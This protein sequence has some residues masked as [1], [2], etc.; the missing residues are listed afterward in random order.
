MANMHPWPRVG[1]A[2]DFVQHVSVS[3][4]EVWDAFVNEDQLRKWLRVTSA[5]I[6]LVAGERYH[7]TTEVKGRGIDRV[8]VIEGKVAAVI[9]NRLLALEWKLLYAGE[10]TCFS[11]QIQQSFAMFGKEC[12]AECDIW[13][14]HSGFPESGKGLFEYDGYSR[15]WRQAI[16]EL[17]A[18]LEHRPGK[19][20]P[21]CL[22][23]LQFVG[24]AQNVGLLVASTVAESPADAA[25]IRPGDII[26]SVDGTPL[27]SL[28]DFHDWIDVRQPGESGLFQLQDRQVRVTT[29]SV[30]TA[31]ER[32]LVRQGD[33]WVKVR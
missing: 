27:H 1:L 9:P 2:V 11:L 16:G 20:A 23:G 12:G 7:L 24:G 26:E 6:P 29:E 19:P 15:H 22:V 30:E 25:G 3:P 18:Y 33:S 21:Y 14:T 8:R 13:I 10:P 4:Q 28:D 5:E 31:R 17:A 32:L